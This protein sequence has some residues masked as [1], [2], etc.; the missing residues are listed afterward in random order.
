MNDPLPRDEARRAVRLASILVLVL[1][2][3]GI[4]GVRVI[5]KY[6]LWR[7]SIFYEQ[8]AAIEP[9]AIAILAVFAII[10]LV[11]ATRAPA[12]DS[13]GDPGET[14]PLAEPVL[15]SGSDVGL[16]VTSAA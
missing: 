2:V 16:R 12:V 13:I 7:R 5:A 11:L 6:E 10:V 4:V 3:A 1:C 15:R 9:P 8:F 14:F